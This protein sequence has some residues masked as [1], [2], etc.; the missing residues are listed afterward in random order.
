AN[1]HLGRDDTHS[2]AVALL[3]VD[4]EINSELLAKIG[5]L[6]GVKQAKALQFQ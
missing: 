3:E 1:F 2:D 6:P 4:Q 5:K